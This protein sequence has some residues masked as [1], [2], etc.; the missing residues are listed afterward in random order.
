MTGLRL[1][2][3]AQTPGIAGLSHAVLAQG[4]RQPASRLKTAPS[5]SIREV[6]D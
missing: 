4:A 2:V 1:C 3:L 6:G 5:I